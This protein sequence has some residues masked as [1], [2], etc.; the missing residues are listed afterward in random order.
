MDCTILI[1]QYEECQL[2]LENPVTLSC[3]NTL[4]QH[5]LDKLNLNDVKFKCFF[6]YKQH[7]IPEEGFTVNK[8]MIKIIESFYQSNSLMKEINESFCELN[9]SIQVYDNINLD[10]YVDD[11]F[12]EIRKRVDINRQESIQEINK[13]SDQI[14]K[15]LKQKEEKCKEN[16]KKIV[17]VD[18]QHFLNN[19]LPSWKQRSK[20]LDKD[21]LENLL[22]NIKQK[23]KSVNCEIENIK[24]QLILNESIEFKKHET[25]QRFGELIT[26]NLRSNLS[27]ECGKLI[28]TFKHK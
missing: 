2:I 27:D 5:H 18:H 6:C 21:G 14:I 8:T 3:G 1:C 17:K 16:A 25:K 9:K 23:I 12:A 15:I 11:Y 4:C 24:N 19:E 28:K 20:K 22:E 13:K 10:N 7:T 26:K